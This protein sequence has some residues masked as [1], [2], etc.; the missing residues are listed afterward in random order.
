MRHHCCVGQQSTFQNFQSPRSSPE[1]YRTAAVAGQPCVYYRTWQDK[2]Q[3]YICHCFRVRI[4]CTPW[5]PPV[6][7]ERR[8][9][10]DVF[11]ARSWVNKHSMVYN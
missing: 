11:T 7:T 6:K 2:Q 5:I 9:G 8:A 3:I 1:H 4:P 10:E